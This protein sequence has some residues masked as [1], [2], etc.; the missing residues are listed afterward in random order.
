VAGESVLERFNLPTDARIFFGTRTV[1]LARE[2][3]EGTAF[4]VLP[5]P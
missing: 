4:A 1:L 5:I 2:L 3:T